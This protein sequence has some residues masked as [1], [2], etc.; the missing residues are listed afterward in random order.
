MVVQCYDF[1]H[2]YSSSDDTKYS[3]K[4]EIPESPDELLSVL[5]FADRDSFNSIYN[6]YLPT[7][8]CNTNI[9]VVDQNA[10]FGESSD[11]EVS[12]TSREGFYH[13][14]EEHELAHLWLP[15]NACD[16]IK[17]GDKYYY[18]LLYLN[19]TSS[20][21]INGYVKYTKGDETRYMLVD[22]ESLSLQCS[23]Y[24]PINYNSSVIGYM[25]NADY[26]S[27]DTIKS[28]IDD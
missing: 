19:G 9:W 2:K 5:G 21:D 12:F 27:V 10:Y 1:I 16:I 7:L 20:M 26:I 18:V 23:E 28:I 13:E 17:I 15:K 3:W 4:E 24:V 6:T 22:Y 8:K 11:Y 25:V 14:D